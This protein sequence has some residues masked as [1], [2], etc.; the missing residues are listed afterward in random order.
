MSDSPSNPDAPSPPDMPHLAP[1]HRAEIARLVA[2][3]RLEAHP[4]GGH[5]RE[6]WRSEATDDAG[7]PSG[8][9]IHFLLPEGVENRWH[10]VDAAEIWHHYAGGRLEL[11][12]AAEDESV[13]RIVLGSNVLAGEIP[14]AIV[15]A[16]AW[17]RARAL[18]GWALCG[19]TVSPAFL[20]ERF[21][22]APPN[23][24]PPGWSP[25]KP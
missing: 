12:I 24:N 14:Q 18:E 15:P 22:L 25:P 6:T 5:Y 20:F 10:R 4:E 23:W 16:G 21:E 7:R 2:A 19:C 11:S 3:L 17:Q 9:A 13:E 1:R 8:T